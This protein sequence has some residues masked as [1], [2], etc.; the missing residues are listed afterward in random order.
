MELFYEGFK[1]KEEQ[2]LWIEDDKETPGLSNLT[3]E[4]KS[5]EPSAIAT[6]KWR[7][8]LGMVSCLVDSDY[9]L[10]VGCVIS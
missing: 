1:S 6:A 10:F 3:E 9:G 5:V 8:I 7:H 2:D 4:H